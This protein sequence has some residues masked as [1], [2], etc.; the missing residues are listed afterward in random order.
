MVYYLSRYAF[1]NG[2]LST[3]V[4]R[5]YNDPVN[6]NKTTGMSADMKTDPEA[7]IKGENHEALVRIQRG[8]AKRIGY[9]GC[10]RDCLGR[11]ACAVGESSGAG[12]Q[13]DQGS[14][15]ESGDSLRG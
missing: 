8:R 9:G 15:Q 4:R 10:R 13:D 3:A 14:I 2:R 5:S 12:G 7:V 11:C 6:T 1:A